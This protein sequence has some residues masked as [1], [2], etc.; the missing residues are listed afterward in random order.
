M[1]HR[2]VW[3]L[4]L[5]GV[6][7][8]IALSVGALAVITRT[9]WGRERVLEYTLT[10]LGGRLRGGLEAERLEGNLITG[11]VLHTVAV[12][13]EDGELILTSDSAYVNYELPT[14]FGGDVVLTE[15]VL[16]SPELFLRRLPTDSLWNYQQLLLDTA[17]VEGPG[18]A[19]LIDHARFVDAE[20]MVKLPWEPEPD[21]P[22]RQREREI[23]EALTDTSRLVVE[24]VPGGYL[25]T[26]YF[27]VE[28]GEITDLVISSDQRG[29]TYLQVAGA[30]GVARLYRGPPLLIRDVQGE[31]ALR[32]GVLRY[33]A[34][35][36]VLPQ[37]RL[38]SVGTVDMREEEP[39]YD[40]VV[41]GRRV[42]FSDLQWL[43]PPLPDEGL[44]TF[45]FWW[46]TRPE[47]TLYRVRDL[48]LTA[49]GTRLVGHFGLV[50][51]GA[52]LF[53]DVELVADPLRVETIEQMLPTE[54]PVRGL[55]IGAVEISSPAS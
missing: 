21:L 18:R 29:G 44:A 35:L 40:L 25:R 9:Q 48:E 20:V 55:H 27:D 31:L 1:R 38:Q 50:V 30:T 43:Y 52:L 10:S 3:T 5:A 13:G 36:I 45:R 6:L 11:A 39:R 47:G 12:R 46:E 24:Q 54:L 23:R 7:A 37:S 34:P 4:V 8:A 33:E 15:L 22:Q 16:Y 51:D 19:T 32:A 2:R 53:S 41:S 17:R 14:F 42:A 26:L 49:P 28:E